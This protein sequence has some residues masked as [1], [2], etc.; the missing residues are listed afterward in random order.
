MVY[1]LRRALV[2]A[3]LSGCALATIG[4]MR[5]SIHLFLPHTAPADTLTGA[6]YLLSTLVQSLASIIGITIAVLFITAQTS[7]RPKFTHAL[8]ELYS[9]RT[10]IAFLLVFFTALIADMLSLSYLSGILGSDALWIIDLDVL[11]TLSAVLLLAPVVL[12]QIENINPLLLAVKLC[13]KV[14]PARIAAYQL[15]NIDRDPLRTNRYRCVLNIWGQQHGL[16]DPL[17]AMHEVIMTAVE[18]KDRVLL[19]GLNRTLLRTIA[20]CAAVPYSTSNHPQSDRR[21]RV[22]RWIYTKTHRP[23]Q[24]PE[25][26]AL[27]LHLLHYSIRRAHNLRR[28]NE[29]GDRDTVRQQY[30]VA[31]RDLIEALSFGKRTGQLIEL[32]IYAMFHIELG[33]GDVPRA[34]SSRSEALAG[35]VPLVGT[36]R[37]RGFTEEGDLLASMLG[38]IDA[39]TD[40]LAM[41]DR[42][43]LLKK[44]EGSAR[45]VYDSSVSQA[46]TDSTW[47]PG[48]EDP[49]AYFLQTYRIVQPRTAKPPRTIQDLPLDAQIALTLRSPTSGIDWVDDAIERA[50][51]YAEERAIRLQGRAKT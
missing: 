42:E 33:Y 3:V 14:T 6:N 7:S 22:W 15:A 16:L 17:G 9:D 12:I 37:E 45:A 43:V 40:H 50:L 36:L 5:G 10:V 25:Q 46:R 2:F 47:L 51:S 39:R 32:C 27:A 19:S 4:V 48:A 18:G 24:L 49:W 44:L 1:R 8:S 30:L 35:Y 21:R 11:L 34:K 31:L 29:W 20:R 38:F 28:P 41:D 13:S 26:L 23:K